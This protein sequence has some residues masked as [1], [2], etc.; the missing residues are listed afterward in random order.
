ML[1]GWQ[2]MAGAVFD[3][4]GVSLF[5]AVVSRKG[6]STWFYYKFH[7]KLRHCFFLT[8]SNSSLLCRHSNKDGFCAC[9]SI[10]TPTVANAGFQ[11]FSSTGH[12][13]VGTLCPQSQSKLGPL[14]T[15][16]YETGRNRWHTGND[17]CTCSPRGWLRSFTPLSR[18]SLQKVVLLHAFASQ[19][20]GKLRSILSILCLSRSWS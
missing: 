15:K 10:G 2:E 7:L 3:D 9:Y 20:C 14:Q 17:R 13:T 12:V 19:P 6:D 4:V 8:G 18:G 1:E 11:Q 16:H 5:V